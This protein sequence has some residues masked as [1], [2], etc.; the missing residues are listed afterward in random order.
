MRGGA[1][2]E[3]LEQEAEALLGLPV[4]DADH[5]E[6]LPLDFRIVDADRAP[7]NFPSVPDDVVGLRPRRARIVRIEL[8]VRRGEGMVVRVPALLLGVPA[9]ERPVDDPG[10]LVRVRIDQAEPLPETAPE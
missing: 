1:I 7:T 6:H 3:R 9:D 5:V 10:D 8:A 2:A 4:V